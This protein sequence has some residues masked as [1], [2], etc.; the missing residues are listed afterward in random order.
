MASLLTL[1]TL[2]TMLL[3]RDQRHVPSGTGTNLTTVVAANMEPDTTLG[4]ENKSSNDRDASDEKEDGSTKHRMREDDD[5]DKENMRPYRKKRWNSRSN[6][7]ERAQ[8]SLVEGDDES[9]ESNSDTTG[10]TR[11]VD[12]DDNDYYDVEDGEED[13]SEHMSDKENTSGTTCSNNNNTNN[14]NAPYW[15]HPDWIPMRNSANC[16]QGT[17]KC[18]GFNQKSIDAEQKSP[19]QIR[20]ELKRYIETHCGLQ[21]SKTALLVDLGVN[22]NSFRKFMDA[23]NYKDPGR[24][25]TCLLGVVKFSL[26]KVHT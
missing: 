1:A 15:M 26:V 23:S 6:H 5:S 8:E 4:D 18:T 24:A 14:E 22:S 2:A 16:G 3:E 25:S 12:D 19:K 9:L 20:T 13:D 21:Y 11:E 10:S 7:A 17:T